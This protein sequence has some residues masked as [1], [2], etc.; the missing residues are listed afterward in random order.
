MSAQL[1]VLHHSPTPLLRD[2]LDAVLAGATLD[3]IE[4]VDVRV[5]EALSV[6][7]DDF[8]DAD[9]YLLGTPA[10][11]GYMSG[12][13]KHA[14]DSTYD[15]TRGKVSR[16]P[17]SFWIHGRSDTTGA[18]RSL[19]SITTGLEWRLAAEPV[20]I[21]RAPTDAQREALVELGGTLAALVAAG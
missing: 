8:L 5:V 16:R 18:R 15:D 7:I 20:E 9:G 19:E 21:L 2:L 3:E 11:F 6:T 4:G 12:A 13:M 17:F 10:N 1:L 14:F